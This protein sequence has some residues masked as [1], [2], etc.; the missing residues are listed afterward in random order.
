MNKVSNSN[1]N[2]EEIRVMQ[3]DEGTLAAKR[4][5]PGP[6]ILMTKETCQG[7]EEPGRV[8]LSG[9]R[10]GRPCGEGHRRVCTLF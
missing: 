9:R 10:T 1:K 2:S 5:W 8:A 7:K 3:R 4:E 6:V